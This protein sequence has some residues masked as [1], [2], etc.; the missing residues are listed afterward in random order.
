MIFGQIKIRINF[1]IFILF[2]FLST[3]SVMA[4]QE[5]Q[6]IVDASGNTFD[7]STVPV[8]VISTSP[9]IT[10]IIYYVGSGEKLCGVTSF[11]DYPPEA[12]NIEKIG[13]L[14]L[15]YEKVLKLKPDVVFLMKGL[16]PKETDI[17][18]SFSIRPFVLDLNSIEGIFNSIDLVAKILNSPK[19]SDE[20]RKKIQNLTSAIKHDNK[21]IVR[22]VYFEIWGN[23]PMSI[24][25]SSFI[26]EIIKKA[27]GH[28]IFEKL[29]T[30]NIPISF[31]KVIE[32]NPEYIVLA[33][34]AKTEEIYARDGFSSIIAIKESNVV[35][36]D[37]NIYVR[38]GPRVFDAIA[39]L[40]EKLYPGSKTIEC[41]LH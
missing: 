17:L 8:R 27:G 2:V 15:N 21:N 36:I 4:N 31:E 25:A 29:D 5:N 18:S 33:Y 37:Y 12:K 6:P 11:C 39:D 38:P 3:S 26:N 7:F 1:F 14:N 9:A 23:P 32:Y 16:R 30:E 22:N 41:E 28:N 35:K 20:L 19:N 34:D 10:E 13:D 40:H 24:G